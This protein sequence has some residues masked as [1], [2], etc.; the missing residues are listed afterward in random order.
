MFKGI[1]KI[2]TKNPANTLGPRVCHSKYNETRIWNGALKKDILQ[3]SSQQFQNSS[4]QLQI[5]SQQCQNSSQQLQIS[6][7]Q[8]Q[9][10]SQQIQISS[11]QLAE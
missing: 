7:Q 9:I 4:Q 8:L 1:N 5:S 2:I 3:I 6:S 11:Q 10:S